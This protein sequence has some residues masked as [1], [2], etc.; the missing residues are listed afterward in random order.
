MHNVV[1]TI[2]YLASVAAT[3]LFYFTWLLCVF[4]GSPS[5][6]LDLPTRLLGA[7][8][9]LVFAGFAPALVVVNIFWNIAVLAHQRLQW[10]GSVFFP[11]VG[12]ISMFTV[13]CVMS[14]LS[15]KPLFI[16]DQSFMDGVVIA[17]ERQGLGLLLAGA[18]FGLANWLL[19]ER[20]RD[21]TLNALP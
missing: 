5:T 10:N 6:S 13:G 12:A 19:F 7:A 17:A 14:S 21:T 8:L 16:E 2:R 18:V 15:P 20:R 3:S 11:I 4:R 9:I 1:R